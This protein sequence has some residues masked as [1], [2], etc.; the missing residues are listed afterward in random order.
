[1]CNTCIRNFNWRKK[2]LP[3]FR[4]QFLGLFQDSLN[5]TGLS[6]SWITVYSKISMF[7]LLTVCHTFHI[8]ALSLIY[9][10]N[11]PGPVALFPVL[12]MQ[13]LATLHDSLIFSLK[14]ALREFDIPGQPLRWRITQDWKRFNHSKWC[15]KLGK[16]SPS[17]ESISKRRKVYQHRG[18]YKNS[19]SNVAIPA[20]GSAYLQ[21]VSSGYVERSQLPYNLCC[22][23][24]FSPRAQ[25]DHPMCSWFKRIYEGYE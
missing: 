1:M 9:L 12:K 14:T 21:R 6:N 2:I 22:D 5:F 11:F 17:E 13:F 4:N 23:W 3:F 19:Q 10:K 15:K 18:P 7:I 20:K 24:N 8:F 16:K 25:A